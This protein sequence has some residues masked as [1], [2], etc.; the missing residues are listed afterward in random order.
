MVGAA[1]STN[2]P[3]LAMSASQLAELVEN[4]MHVSAD[5]KV[6]CVNQYTK[7]MVAPVCSCASCGVRTATEM[8]G[9]ALEE[10]TIRGRFR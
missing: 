10:R 4:D 9:A 2:I 3:S 8:P 7:A 6:A 5:E 1:A